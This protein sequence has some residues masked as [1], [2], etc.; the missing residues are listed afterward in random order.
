MYKGFS[1]LVLGLSASVTFTVPAN[2]E[3]WSG[4]YKPSDRHT[5]IRKSQ[6]NNVGCM[7][8]ILSA[9]E[10]YNIPNNLLLAIGIQEA[11]R[12]T[13]GKTTIWPWAVNA[14]GKGIFFKSRD[15]AIGWIKNQQAQGMRSIDVG[16]MQINL[17]WHRG[18]FS[19]LEEAFDPMLNADYAARFLSD[20]RKS[21]GSWWEAAGSYHSKTAVHRNRY[22][23]AL[24][25]NQ[26]IANSLSVHIQAVSREEPVRIS[27]AKAK[28]HSVPSVLWGDSEIDHS[29]FSIYSRSPITPVLPNFQEGL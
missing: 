28:P 27:R 12:K 17:R 26:K 6:N 13:K 10:R 5:H 8:A 3:L 7:A 9:Q 2:A 11:G 29:A 21:E 19:S 1:L 16:C 4:F 18:A 25:H 23:T 20:L 22:L 14:E 24:A 15:Q